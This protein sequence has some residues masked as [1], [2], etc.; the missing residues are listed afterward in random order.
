MEDSAD[1]EDTEWLNKLKTV[2][3]DVKTIGLGAFQ[4]NR[5]AF[6]ATIKAE[7]IGE[8][9]CKCPYRRQDRSEKEE[10]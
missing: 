9:I 1:G 5:G 8:S 2:N 10:R 3:I 6:T 7:T 4:D